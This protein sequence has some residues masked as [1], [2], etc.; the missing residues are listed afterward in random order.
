MRVVFDT[1]I[2]I[3]ALAIPG[4][5]AGKAVLKIIEG[6][7]TLLTS[8][9]LLDELL[10]T[11]ARKFSHDAEQLSRVAVNISEL[12]EMVRAGKRIN[13]LKDD[14]D[15]RVL[16]CAVAG[17]ADMIITG[18]KEM[19]GLKGYKGIKVI[20]LRDYLGGEEGGQA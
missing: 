20:S 4:S 10:S 18:D 9:V 13:V 1:N 3:S 14:P 5:L 16:E 11:L 15:N 19:L 2:F 6:E 8:R 17:K 12:A 7:D